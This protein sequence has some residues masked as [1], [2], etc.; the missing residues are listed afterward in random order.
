MAESS[1]GQCDVEEEKLGLEDDFHHE[2]LLQSLPKCKGWVN[3][4][5]YYFQNFWSTQ[6][7]VK[8]TISIQKHFQAKD[9]D[10]FVTSLP[11]TGT[12]WLKALV[13]AVVKRHHFNPSQDY[14]PLLNFNSHTLVPYFEFDIY[15][16]NPND[17]DLFTLPEPR[18]FSTHIPFPSLSHSVHNSNCKIIYISRNPFDAFISLWHFSNNILSSRSLPTLP[19]EEAF[20]RYCEGMHPCG[21]FWSHQLG[22]WK[23]SKDTPNKVLFLKYEELKANTKFGLK[24]M[25]QFLDCPF[26][27]EEESGGV[28]D[29]IIELCSFKKMK[30][31]EINKNGKV[32]ENVEN[33][34]FFRKGETGDWI[35]YFSPWMTEK[36]SKVIEQKLDIPMAESSVDHCD[37]EEEM[38]GLEDDFH[39]AELLQS[40]PKCKE[41]VDEHSYFFQNFWCNQNIVKATISFQKHFQAKDNDIFLTSLPKTGTTWLKALVFAVVKRHHFNP[42]QNDH[43]LLNFNSHT[44]VPF[45]EFD[46]YGDNPN[47]FD[48][49]TLAEPRMF[50]THIPFPSLSHSIHNSNCKII[51][52]SRNP[53]D[54]FISLWHFSNNILSSRS[55]PTL[56][57]E[58]AFERY[59][60]GIHP[61]GPFWSHQLG[62]WKASKDT[63]NKVLFLKYEELKA[64][65]NFELKKM[66]QFLGCPFTE[67][68]ESG[69]IIDDIIELCS[70]KKMKELEINKSGKALSNVENKNYFRKGETGDWV[71]YFLPWMT[72]KLSKVV[73][74][75]LGGMM[76]LI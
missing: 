19:L 52:I 33:K 76:D 34:H 17:F 75:K 11:K 40:L 9:N 4:H 56:T 60:E 69:G 24:K 49:T 14:H 50:G 8:T 68:E 46:I 66:A 74:Q 65:T 73:E 58:E 44:L 25:A 20:E 42:S 13:F 2:E 16:D 43:P 55:L 47:D 35:N 67:E 12:T 28:I 36:L 10:I 41:W 71:N 48:L 38:F 37:D 62:Y 57:L 22:Y 5:F 23:A 15:G 32:L 70:F 18:M 3:P 63:P 1:V 64:N 53:F 26:S 7:I 21:P 6:N 39:H 31:L 72:E 27:E 61:C 30:E 51:Y 29:S 54:A 59:C 45:F